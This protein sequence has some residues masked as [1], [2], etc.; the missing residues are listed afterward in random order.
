MHP[1]KYLIR[2]E[3]IFLILKF[4]SK[5]NWCGWFHYFRAVWIFSLQ[6]S[7]T[8]KTTFTKSKRYKKALN[9]F[10]LW[11]EMLLCSHILIAITVFCARIVM[12][13]F[14]IAFASYRF[15][16]KFNKNKLVLE[17]RKSF[18][19]NT[20]ELSWKQIWWL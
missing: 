17:R 13:Q 12:K 20:F 15:T 10:S 9:R 3:N 14:L 4:I 11:T 5:S 6:L 19:N 7:R 16:S 8:H 1:A 2:K 18:S